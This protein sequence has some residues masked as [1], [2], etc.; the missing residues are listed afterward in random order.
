VD[1]KVLIIGA[2]I[3]G[4]ASAALL[5]REGFNVSIIEKNSTVGGR[6]RT[7]SSGGYRFDMGPSWYL[8][9]E[10]FEQFFHLFKRNREEFY[11]LE[12]LDPAYSV[13]FNPG[14]SVQVRS[15]REETKALFERFERGGGKKLDAYLDKAEYKYKIA[16]GEFLYKNYTSP[17]DFLN[18]KLIIEGSRLN[19]FKSLDKV[20][21][22]YFSDR[23]A[24]QILEYGMVF[25]GTN[26]KQAPALYS[27]MS[28]MDLNQGVFYPHGGLAEIPRSIASLA[29]SLGVEIITDTPVRKILVDS[30][31]KAA[32]VLTDQGKIEADIVVVN[33]DYS[34]AET[35]LL[36]KE[37]QSFPLSYW[38]KRVWAPSMFILYL[39]L[40]KRLDSLT[41]HNLYFAPDWDTHF[42]T[43]FKK[44]GWPGDPCFYMSCISKSDIDS[45]PDGGEN[46]FVLIPVAPGLDDNEEQREGYADS[47]IKHIENITGE[48][49]HDSI[50]VKRIYSQRDFSAD[51]NAFQGTAL[52][53]AH[54]LRQ[55]AFFRPSL[56]SKRVSNLYYTGQY[57]HPGVGVPMVLISSQVMT[58]LIKEDAA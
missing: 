55:T 25:L 37:Y 17:F 12:K 4:L 1:K 53:L 7:W 32:G 19:V 11:Q 30:R 43:I 44:P 31:G 46:V 6:A 58:G 20:V 14:E 51:Y 10:V 15:D 27:I 45:A 41:H 21:G 52:G 35:Q 3:G 8:M 24:R 54:T 36:D 49:I 18:K 39:G 23:R 40:N 2:G 48:R 22:K 42:D 34:F 26:P 38:N 57:T 29:E 56:R 16:V 50:A 13:F 47:V 5:A 9:P 33:A 28:H